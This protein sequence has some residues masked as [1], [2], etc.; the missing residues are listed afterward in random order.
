MY[1]FKKK[2]LLQV[3]KFINLYI[4]ETSFDVIPG[5]IEKYRQ[6]GKIRIF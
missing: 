1:A 6:I 5:K 4:S 2:R 3:N